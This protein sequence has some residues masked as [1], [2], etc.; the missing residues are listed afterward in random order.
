MPNDFPYPPSPPSNPSPHLSW[1]AMQTSPKRH[2]SHTL[3]A[4]VKNNHFSPYNL[5]FSRIITSITRGFVQSLICTAAVCGKLEIRSAIV[6]RRR[7]E[8]IALK[9][10][11]VF[12]AIFFVNKSLHTRTTLK[13]HH[14][15]VC[16]AKKT[17][18]NVL[19]LT[20][21][22]VLLR[23]PAPASNMIQTP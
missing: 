19:P 13:S 17:V 7:R 6:S 21:P 20:S 3:Y 12:F 22:T 14:L 1:V 23:R 9:I 16:T 10:S 8:T 15:D 5:N 2:N 4:F 11:Y 18:E